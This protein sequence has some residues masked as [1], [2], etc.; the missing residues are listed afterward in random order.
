ML[1][2]SLVNYVYKALLPER[3]EAEAVIEDEEELDKII[4][5]IDEQ[6]PRQEVERLNTQPIRSENEA[7]KC[8]DRVGFITELSTNTGIIDN[9]YIFDLEDEFAGNL[10]IGSKV[11]YKAYR[12]AENEE[13]RVSYIFFVMVLGF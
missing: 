7:Y 4:E 3:E 6:P 1:A 13:W 2:F 12:L 11:S 5:A 10:K 9:Q 8:L